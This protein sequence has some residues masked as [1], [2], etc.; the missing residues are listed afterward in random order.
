MIYTYLVVGFDLRGFEIDRSDA[1]HE[2]LELVVAL[3]Y[4]KNQM[5]TLYSRLNTIKESQ[6]PNDIYSLALLFKLCA[7]CNA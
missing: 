3:Y 4:G 1:P 7:G 2:Q 6:R 5:R